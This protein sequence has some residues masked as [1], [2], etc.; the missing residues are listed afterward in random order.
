MDAVVVLVAVADIAVGVR[1]SA[2]AVVGRGSGA[3]VAAGVGAAVEVVVGVLDGVTVGREDAHATRNIPMTTSSA[4]MGR[5][6]IASSIGS[7]L[8][9]CVVVQ[10]AI[11]QNLLYHGTP[12]EKNRRP[13][14]P[15]GVKGERP[16]AIAEPI[17]QWILAIAS[18][19]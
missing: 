14:M 9:D 12:L 13:R 18:T 10:R 11:G 5:G 15:M 7:V 16:V 17:T 1:E 19:T 4:T 2:G 8:V 6:L 3:V